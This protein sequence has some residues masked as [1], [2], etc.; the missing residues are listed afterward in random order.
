MSKPEKFDRGNRFEKHSMVKIFHI[1]K[2]FGTLKPP[3]MVVYIDQPDADQYIAS[4]LTILDSANTASTRISHPFK[5]LTLIKV[6]RLSNLLGRK[7]CVLTRDASLF[8]E[9]TSNLIE[10]T[11]A[12]INFESTA[13]YGIAN[14]LAYDL[15]SLQE[16]TLSRCKFDGKQATSILPHSKPTIPV[17][18]K[19]LRKLDLSKNN[20]TDGE[21]Q[22]LIA[23]VL[24]MAKHEVLNVDNNDFSY[25]NGYRVFSIIKFLRTQQL[26]VKYSS[27]DVTAFLTILRFIKTI[28]VENS[29]SVK[30]ICVIKQL[31]LSIASHH[32]TLQDDVSF[33][34]FN[35]LVQLN[36]S[37]III[38]A[39][40]ANVIADAI[41]NELCSV[42]VLALTHCQ[43][44]SDSVMLIL[45]SDKV[46]IPAAFKRLST[47]DLSDNAIADKAV[48]S[49]VASLFKCLISLH[50]I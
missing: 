29:V 35:S 21:T 19:M 25:Q 24:Q 15:C 37:G 42:Q 45:P 40:A 39:T 7:E 16:L 1:I 38:K 8:F 34:R 13:V 33:S 27:E 5:K 6:L 28:Q 2:E 11:M 30:H 44:D 17:A 20:I 22:P 12:G 4:F 36:M 31:D 47:L 49:L 46:S 23:S 50:S 26:S 10:M 32:V 14:A 3:Q 9:S 18:F 43:L 48:H 41:V